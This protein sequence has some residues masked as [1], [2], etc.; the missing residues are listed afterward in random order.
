MRDDTGRAGP[1][2]PAAAAIDDQGVVRLRLD[3]ANSGQIL[4][5]SPSI[6]SVKYSRF[7]G[8]E[9]RGF[10]DHRH[11][12]LG[13]PSA[14]KSRRNSRVFTNIGARNQQVSPKV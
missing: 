10:Q 8:T 9:W 4:S 3:R 7:E 13:H 6:R 14:S 1:T 5:I 2:F 12:P 11:R